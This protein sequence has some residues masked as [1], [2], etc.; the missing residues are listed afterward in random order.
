MNDKE[1]LMWLRDRL[2]FQ[3]NEK[4]NVDYMLKLQAIIN[5]TP[6]NKLTPNMTHTSVMGFIE[7]TFLGDI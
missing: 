1:F 3:Y 2:H 4:L 5:D 7:E 6:E